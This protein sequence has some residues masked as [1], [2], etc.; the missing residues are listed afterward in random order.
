MKKT[1][2]HPL[3]VF[4]SLSLI[5][6]LLLVG[7]LLYQV[8]GVTDNDNNHSVRPTSPLVEESQENY[9]LSWQQLIKK[10]FLKS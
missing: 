6:T 9:Q 4:G 1:M 8:K 2:R 7:V 10:K 3:I 5:T